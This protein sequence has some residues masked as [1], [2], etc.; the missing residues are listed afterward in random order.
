MFPVRVAGPTTFNVLG[1]WAQADPNYSAAIL[2]GLTLYRDFLREGPS[3]LLGD[4]NSSVAWDE[5]HGRTDHRDLEGRLRQE[6]GLVS[7]YHAATA[8]PPGTETRPKRFW[9]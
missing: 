7:A 1:V 4:F 8:E 5:K 3:I 2:Q 9:R 6:F